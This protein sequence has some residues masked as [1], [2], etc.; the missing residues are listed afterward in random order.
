MNIHMPLVYGLNL[1]VNV[2]AFYR[3]RSGLLNP[4]VTF[5]MVLAGT[6]RGLVLF[7]A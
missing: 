6:I 5:G 2:W 7:P 3:I 4:A 1:L